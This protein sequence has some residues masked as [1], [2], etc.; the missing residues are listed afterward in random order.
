[1]QWL[2]IRTAGDMRMNG[3]KRLRCDEDQKDIPCD[4][5]FK[6]RLSVS[7]RLNAGRISGMPSWRVDNRF[8][9]QR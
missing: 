7:T 9:R 4:I 2:G 5:R 3:R 1:M 8:E 6:G